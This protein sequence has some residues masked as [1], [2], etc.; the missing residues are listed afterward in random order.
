MRHFF[1]ILSGFLNNYIRFS[2]SFLIF[3]LSVQ[4]NVV[5]LHSQKRNNLSLCSMNFENENLSKKVG[6]KFGRFKMFVVTL[7]NN[8]LAKL[9]CELFL[10]L[11]R[12]QES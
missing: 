5:S 11:F 1:G 8:R 6:E 2:K 4:K 9:I 7:Q 12:K 10:P 3:D